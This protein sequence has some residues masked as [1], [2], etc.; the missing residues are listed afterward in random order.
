LFSEVIAQFFRTSAF[1]SANPLLG[2]DDRTIPE[3]RLRKAIAIVKRASSKF[4][5]LHRKHI[6]ALIK[7]P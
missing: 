1:A 2:A 7:N 3:S 5:N 4:E 6:L